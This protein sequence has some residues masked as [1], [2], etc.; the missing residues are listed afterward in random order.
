[1]DAS[2]AAH[3]PDG[4]APRWT[5][6]YWAAGK[7]CG[8]TRLRRVLG[9]RR[10]RKRNPDLVATSSTLHVADVTRGRAASVYVGVGPARPGEA[11]LVLPPSCG[12]RILGCLTI[13]SWTLRLATAFR[14]DDPAA[15]RECPRRNTRLPY[16]LGG[17]MLKRTAIRWY[18]LTAAA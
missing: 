18:L 14:L 3:S 15:P 9:T 4:V 12:R 17:S 16:S 8:V 1:M 13:R 6:P 7:F 5:G 2:T 10:P 11:R